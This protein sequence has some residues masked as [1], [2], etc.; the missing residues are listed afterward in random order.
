MFVS[1][2]PIPRPERRRSGTMG[3]AVEA[4]PQR[5]RHHLR[6][7][8]ADEGQLIM[9]PPLTPLIGQ[10]PSAS[11]A[12]RR[13]HPIT[14]G[15]SPRCCTSPRRRSGSAPPPGRL[16]L[17]LPGTVRGSLP[18]VPPGGGSSGLLTLNRGVGVRTPGD[19]CAHPAAADIEN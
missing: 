8:D 15:A 5:L 17:V 2:H 12:T 3:R 19:A 16:Y 13:Q 11:A 1:G 14:P 4:S 9:K 6:R 18:W 7:P 10:T